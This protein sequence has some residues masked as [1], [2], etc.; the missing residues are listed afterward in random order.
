MSDLSSFN[1]SSNSSNSSFY[2]HTHDKKNGYF[3]KVYSRSAK[4][5]NL[6]VLRDAKIDGS[7]NVED[8]VNIEGTIRLPV[9]V[10][11]TV[12][13]HRH[14]TIQCAINHFEGRHGMHGVITVL[15]GKGSGPN[16]S[17]VE[18]IRVNKMS[19]NLDKTNH[20]G[21]K[22]IG[23]HRPIMGTTFLQNGVHS[24]SLAVLGFGTDSVNVTLSNTNNTITVT[25]SSGPPIN[26]LMSGLVI[27]DK[28]KIR[29]NTGTWFNASISSIL[30][31]TITHTAGNISVGSI[32]SALILCPNVELCG[33]VHGKPAITVEG[34]SLTLSGF[35]VNSDMSHGS[36]LNVRDN[37]FVTS[38]ANVGVENCVFDNST[39]NLTFSNITVYD[40]ASLILSKTN[41]IAFLTASGQQMP[42]T[43]IGSGTETNA[44]LLVTDNSSVIGG[45]QSVF[46]GT[47]FCN[48]VS[49]LSSVIGQYVGSS[50]NLTQVALSVSD[51]AVLNTQYLRVYYVTGSSPIGI[52]VGRNSVATL[53]LPG[54]SSIIDCN[55]IPNSRAIYA[56]NA[57]DIVLYDTQLNIQNVSV[58]ISLRGVS[59]FSS[60]ISTA[61]PMFSNIINE[62]VVTDTLS[63]YDQSS[64]TQ[65][66]GNILTYLATPPFDLENAFSNQLIAAL[67]AISIPLDPELTY[68]D[69]AIYIG[70]TFTITAT[71]DPLAK[72]TVTLINGAI[73]KGF[74]FN[75]ATTAIF[76][77]EDSF[78]KILVESV[79][80]VR[81]ISYYGMSFI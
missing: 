29:D 73:F 31:N 12:P 17:Y 28:I 34:A 11:L 47:V 33:A 30:G 72:H 27:G 67:A 19:S 2:K 49:S 16:G 60:R 65:T 40:N 78:I 1:S 55:S 57:A 71:T 24:N 74:G 77:A 25:L 4:V 38:S 63:T 22:I 26:F 75:G 14:P 46:D 21:F 5:K 64:S 7:L 15:P 61:V 81:L 23:D 70:K 59:T 10:H 18:S 53:C 44:A 76:I 37:L 66:L 20:H 9:S 68:N 35:W 6:K 80:V 52:S 48:Q 62:N 36:V 41:D 51:N 43:I 8:D 42:T 58:A 13:T 39:T 54:S 50:N 32:G 69:I 79:S 56:N 3:S 45:A